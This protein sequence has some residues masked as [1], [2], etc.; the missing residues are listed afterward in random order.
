VLFIIITDGMENAS[1]EFSSNQV[2]A[3]IEHEKEKY[4]W[5]FIF[6]GANI[7]AVETAG[8]FGIGSDRALDYVADSV[9][10]TL[11]FAA[12]SETVAGFRKTGQVPVEPMEAIRNDMKKRGGRK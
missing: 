4:G 8:R 9:G 2:K 11:N 7:D 10:T 12:M 1:R 5:E 3:M 6:L